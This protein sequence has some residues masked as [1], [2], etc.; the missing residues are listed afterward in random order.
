MNVAAAGYHVDVA[1][2]GRFHRETMPG[3]LHAVITALGRQAPAVDGAFGYCELGC[4]DGLNL[5]LAA[6][7]HPR[8]RFVGLDLDAAHVE[9]A[10]ASARAADVRNVDFLQGDVAQ[11]PAGLTPGSF[12]YVVSHGMWSW[13]PDAVR[14]AGT[15]LASTLLRPDGVAYIGYMSHPGAT[16][17]AP[18]QRLMRE[19]SASAP[20]NAAQRATQALAFALRLAEAGAGL[21]AEHPGLAVQ[22]QA[23]A[24]ES[25]EHLAHEFLSGHWQP[26]HAADVLQAFETA[27]ASWIGSAT[28]IE[29]IDALSLP[30]QVLPLL[31]EARGVGLAE[32]V[33]DAA[34]HQSLRR[35]LFQRGGQALSTQ[36]HLAALDAITWVAT[37]GAPTSGSVVLETRIGPV[38]VPPDVCDLVL[39]RLA[40]GPC[41]H[42]ELRT[43]PP[44]AQRP[45]ILNQLTQAL[46]WRGC[47]HP[48]SRA[49]ASTPASLALQAQLAARAGRRW[50]PWLV[51]GSAIAI[52]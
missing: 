44:F 7:A 16:V 21:F 15:R 18:L 3:W 38:Q 35:D 30:G 10:R 36:A 34:R 52:S 29:N 28:P 2:P 19:V 11:A 25:P 13:M 48:A 37:P 39:R 47:L 32:T 27:G 45:D 8:A 51:G 4:G 40:V 24:K 6:V 20:G 12:D 22:L 33:K 14:A 5:L 46:L 49:P 26:L 41:P 31:R 1:Y 50:R 42:G 9:A 43:M 23:M 17:L